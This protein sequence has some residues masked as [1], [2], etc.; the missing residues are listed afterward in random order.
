MY[1]GIPTGKQK[2]DKE[3]WAPK[4]KA[5]FGEEP[6]SIDDA[7]FKNQKSEKEA[8]KEA[9]RIPGTDPAPVHESVFGKEERIRAPLHEKV[10]GRNEEF[11]AH[12]RSM[13]LALR[14]E[15]AGPFVADE[16]GQLFREGRLTLSAFREILRQAVREYDTILLPAAKEL[17]MSQ[18]E[19]QLANM[20]SFRASLSDEK[21][22]KEEY[23]TWVRMFSSAQKD[24][25]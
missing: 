19:T 13:V 5:V 15:L 12:E 24:S 21:R 20:D 18:A 25:A 10:F 9:R 7:V 16:A 22:L 6:H 3:S 23:D 14:D 11:V 2:L 8:A 4:H 1:E 17:G